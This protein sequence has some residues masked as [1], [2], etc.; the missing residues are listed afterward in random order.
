M[1]PLLL[2]LAAVAAVRGRIQT[3]RVR[4]GVLVA[5]EPIGLVLGHNKVAEE[6]LLKGLPV[7]RAIAHTPLAVAVAA[8]LLSVFNQTTL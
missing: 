8:R 1:E 5:A 7:G 2:P 3:L 4:M 6:L